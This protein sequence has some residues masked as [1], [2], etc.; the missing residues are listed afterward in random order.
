MKSISFASDQFVPIGALFQSQI[1]IPTFYPSSS[2]SLNMLLV[3]SDSDE[4]FFDSD[5][6]FDSIDDY[7]YNDSINRNDTIFQFSYLS[8]RSLFLIK[9][10][11]Q[12]QQDQTL[13]RPWLVR[14]TQD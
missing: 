12:H 13:I 7:K 2:H 6:F 3:V 4:E 10:P 11:P 8:K 5:Y 1:T 9:P 14:I